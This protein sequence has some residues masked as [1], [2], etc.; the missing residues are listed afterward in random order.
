MGDILQGYKRGMKDFH[1]PVLVKETIE[2]LAVQ[3]GKKY[4]DATVGGGGHG[5]EILKRG[6]RLL[7]IDTDQKALEYTRKR[8]RDLEIKRSTDYI[9]VQGN[10]R[11]INKIADKY[12]FRLTDGILFDLGVSS[13]QLDAAGR[14]FS[15]RFEGADLDMRLDQ[16]SGESAAD[17]L[18]RLSE[19]ELY[20]IFATYG[21]EKHSRIIAHAL[22][23][24]RKIAPINKIDSLVKIVEGIAPG[25]KN[26]TL[27]RIFQ[28]IRMAVNEEPEA[29]REGLEGAEKLLRMG[30]RLVVISFHS[31]EDRVVKQFLRNNSFTVLTKKPITAG[32]EEL[33][34]NSRARSAKLRI[35]EKL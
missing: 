14:G 28:A 22:V 15:Y 19:E 18:N 21:E 16:T 4:I 6:G 3:E 5:I 17:L 34:E 25:E 24:A 8:L 10:F 29:L 26:A 23:R 31:L 9:L 35:A 2:G 33:K 12:G 30:G 32:P 13:H 1:K 7:G 11:Q 20:E 27:S